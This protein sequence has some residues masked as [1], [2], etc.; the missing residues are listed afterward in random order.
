M[1]NIQWIKASYFLGQKKQRKKK[2]PILSNS[3]TKCEHFIPDPKPIFQIHSNINSNPPTPKTKNKKQ[4]T[5]RQFLS[6]W[7]LVWHMCLKTENCCL[8][9]F[10]EIRVSEKVWK[11]VK[12]CLKTENCCFKNHIFSAVCF[13]IQPLFLRCLTEFQITLQDL[14]HLKWKDCRLLLLKKII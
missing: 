5:H 11:Y 12:C 10:V 2:S 7:E 13:H 4:K 9:T 14:K 1:T 6:S 3:W 8:K